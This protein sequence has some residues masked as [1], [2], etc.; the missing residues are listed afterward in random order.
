V[1][2]LNATTGQTLWSY[3]PHNNTSANEYLACRGVAYYQSP[4]PANA[5]CDRRIISTTAD[6]KLIA[7][8]VDAWRL[9]Q[10]FWAG[11]HVT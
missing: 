7:L 10:D 11:C 2:A 8:D 5:P 9:C 4:T 3:D 1:L 6:A